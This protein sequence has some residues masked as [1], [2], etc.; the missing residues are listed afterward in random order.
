[1]SNDDNC[2]CENAPPVEGRITAAPV[3]T[4]TSSPEPSV[5]P[6]LPAAATPGPRMQAIPRLPPR[7]GPTSRRVRSPEMIQLHPAAEFDSIRDDG[8]R[9]RVIPPLFNVPPIGPRGPFWAGGSTVF[10]LDAG[11]QLLPL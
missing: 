9:F 10:F 11:G 5:A 6:A 8:P 1:M 3:P 4:R 7:V 2:G